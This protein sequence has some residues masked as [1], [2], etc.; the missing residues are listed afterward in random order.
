MKRIQIQ[1]SRFVLLPTIIHLCIFAISFA[2]SSCA[3]D[4]IN[5]LFWRTDNPELLANDTL[6]FDA[7]IRCNRPGT[8]HSSLLLSFDYNNS[9]FGDSLVSKGKIDLIP[10]ELMEGEIQSLP[11][12]EISGL[13]DEGPHC[14]VIKIQ[15]LYGIPDPLFMNEVDTL[16]NGLIR[17][18]I[19]FDNTGADNPDVVFSRTNMNGEA[20]YLDAAHPVPA[21]YKTPYFYENNWFLTVSNR[22]SLVAF[23]EGPFESEQM[24]TYLNSGGHL[25][26]MQPFNVPPWNYNGAEEVCMIPNPGIVDWVLLELRDLPSPDDPNPDNVILRRACFLLKNGV[27]TGLNGYSQLQCYFDVSFGLYAIL[28]HRNHLGIMTADS[29]STCCGFYEYDFSSGADAVFGGSNGHKELSSGIWGMASGDGN[30]DGN[31]DNNDKLEVWDPQSGNSG[32]LNGDFSLD[33]QVNHQDKIDQWVPN[34]GRSCMVP[35]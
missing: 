6:Q 16:F 10:L 5:T 13:Y 34:A 35:D 33:G 31:V 25:Q 3:Q 15:A 11:L 4:T 8:F 22:L 32:Y 24:N 12:Y 9:P 1:I 23:L 18:K 28:W 19:A 30:G 29:L 27:V 7:E 2:E 21:I 14:F 17:L 26:L 20:F